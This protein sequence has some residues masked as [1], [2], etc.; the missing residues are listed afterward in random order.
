MQWW[1]QSCSG[2]RPW[3]LVLWPM[4]KSTSNRKR[5]A[6]S[7]VTWL[8]L[9]SLLNMKIQVTRP[10]PAMISTPPWTP[11]RA[12]SLWRG[13]GQVTVWVKTLR[14]YLTI[15]EPGKKDWPSWRLW[16]VTCSSW[17]WSC[18]MPSRQRLRSLQRVRPKR[19]RLWLSPKIRPLAMVPLQLVQKML[20]NLQPKKRR[21]RTRPLWR[22]RTR[23]LLWRS[24][25]LW[26]TS[27]SKSLQVSWLQWLGFDWPLA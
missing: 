5:G 27:N 9:L 24:F 7:Q 17:K 16:P 22:S 26:R 4:P 20:P 11:T 14:R 21:L 13:Q 3:S 18:W 8:L 1:R 2:R 23:P 25:W 6:G 15:W 19:P 12:K 10:C